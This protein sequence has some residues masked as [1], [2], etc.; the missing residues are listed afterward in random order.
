MKLCQ[1]ELEPDRPQTKPRISTL[2]I[3]NTRRQT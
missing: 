3:N 1:E 2:A